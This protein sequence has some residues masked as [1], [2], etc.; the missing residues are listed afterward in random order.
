MS[1]NVQRIT[2]DSAIQYSYVHGG[3]CCGRAHIMSFGLRPSKLKKKQ[4]E[5]FIKSPAFNRSL[6]WEITLTKNQTENKAKEYTRES[7][8]NALLGYSENYKRTGWEKYK[9]DFCP[10]SWGEILAQN[11]FEI[12]RT[13]R[14]PNSGNVVNVFM[15]RGGPA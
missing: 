11:G 12:V 2:P 1:S 13:F 15:N 7:Y 8:Y 6:C 4:F 5:D 3:D 9:R 10:E 14:N